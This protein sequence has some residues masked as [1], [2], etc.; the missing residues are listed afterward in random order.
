MIT[1]VAYEY[2]AVGGGESRAIEL[3]RLGTGGD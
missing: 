3:G 1:C 2:L